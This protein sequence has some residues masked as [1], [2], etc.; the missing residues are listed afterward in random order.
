MTG[1]QNKFISSKKG[2]S[3]HVAFENDSSIKIHGKG[4]VNL[5]SE[6]VKATMSCWLNILRIISL[7]SGKCVINDTLSLLIHKIVKSEKQIQEDWLQ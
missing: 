5:G 4:V 6:K 2:K 1:D 3:G 7:V